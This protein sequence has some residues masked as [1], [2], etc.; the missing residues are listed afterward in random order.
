ME[1]HDRRDCRAV[2]LSATRQLDRHSFEFPSLRHSELATL[3]GSWPLP[4]FP[5]VRSNF[6][7]FDFQSRRGD[8]IWIP[9]RGSWLLQ[10]FIMNCCRSWKGS[11]SVLA[12]MRWLLCGEKKK[13]SMTVPQKKKRSATVH[14]LA[15][16]RFIPSTVKINAR[17]ITASEHLLQNHRVWVKQPSARHMRVI[18]TCCHAPVACRVCFRHR[19][20]VLSVN[21]D[22]CACSWS[23]LRLPLRAGTHVISSLLSSSWADGSARSTSPKD[24]AIQS[25]SHLLRSLLR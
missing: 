7:H 15:R 22:S 3:G 4:P 5:R 17:S 8:I 9:F 1:G 24:P 10:Q 14:K 18:A 23:A 21:R 13:T 20:H 6:S 12:S 2:A 25:N 11:A 19:T 16:K